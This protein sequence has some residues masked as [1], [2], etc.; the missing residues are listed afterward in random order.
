MNKDELVDAIVAKT[1]LAKKDV[2]AVISGFVDEIT[3]QLQKGEKVTLSGFG[4]FRVSDRAA[5]TGINPRNPS[6][7]IQIPATKTPK[8][9]A[10]KTLKDAIK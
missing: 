9:K 4:T 7:K 5:R 6:E 3:A 8:F 2:D 1:S 10:G